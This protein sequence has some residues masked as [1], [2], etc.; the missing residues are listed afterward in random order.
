MASGRAVGSVPLPEAASYAAFSAGTT[1]VAVIDESSI[2]V[3]DTASSKALR[4]LEAVELGVQTPAQAP[5]AVALS[6]DGM[7][8]AVRKTTSPEIQLWDVRTGTKIRGMDQAAAPA[9]ANEAGVTITE[10]AGVSTPLLVFSPDGKSLA[11]AGP[12]WQL[13]LWDVATGQLRHELAI[14]A[15]RSIERFAFSA[16]SHVLGII[17]ADANVTLYELATG[18]ERCRLGRGSGQGG[19]CRSTWAASRSP[20]LSRRTLRRASAC[21]RMVAT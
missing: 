19:A 16:D 1:R 4:T 15:G 13:C 11:G 10:A 7:T 14:P 5:I 8:L 18:Q 20:S 17:D 2:R 6:P 21:P 12:K 3:F 9:N